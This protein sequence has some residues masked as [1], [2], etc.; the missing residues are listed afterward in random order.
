MGLAG[1]HNTQHNSAS[2]IL[3][4]SLLSLKLSKGDSGDEAS[5]NATSLRQWRCEDFPL[6]E[7]S[8][9]RQKLYDIQST[10]FQ[11]SN[12]PTEIS[13]YEDP[14]MNLLLRNT[15]ASLL[16]SLVSSFSS[17]NSSV[18]E[19]PLSA[20]FTIP[21]GGI[22]CLNTIRKMS[23]QKACIGVIADKGFSR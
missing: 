14:H 17:A 4:E 23:C 20:C 7:Q 12:E 15:A 9:S 1:E 18:H 22:L 19:K 11:S 13:Y 16:D 10:S 21:C 3:F 2:G 8:W 5:T 6:L